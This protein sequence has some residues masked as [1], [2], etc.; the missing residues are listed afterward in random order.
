MFNTIFKKNAFYT[1]IVSDLNSEGAGVIKIDGFPFFVEGVIPGEEI[2]FKAIK[3]QKNYGYGKIQDIIQSSPH[4][5]APKD[6]LG[7]QI[8]TMTLQHLSYPYQLIF[9]QKV[10]QDAF[11]RIGHFQDLSIHPPLGMENPWHY[12]NKAQI[13]VRMINGLLE[14][15]FYRQHSH[16]LIPIED[17]HIQHPEID[18]AILIIR[19]LLRQYQISAY[20][21]TH[22]KGL[23]RHL[24]VKRGH[25]S[26]Q[27]MVIL[28]TNGHYGSQMLTVAQAIHEA[29]PQVVSIIQNIQT[30]QT[31]VILGPDNRVLWGQDY[32]EDTMLNHTLRISAHSFYQVNTPQAEVLY[33]TAINAAQLK[34]QET[35][36]DAYSGIGSIALSLAPHASHVYAMEIVPE[37]I[38]MA[39]QNAKINH[40]ENITFEL[41]SAPEWMTRWDQA[42]I[43]FDVALVDPPRKGLD[44]AFITTLVGQ[45]PDR[46]VY[47]SCNPATLARD[48]RLMVDAGYRITMVQPVDLFAQTKHVECVALLTK[49]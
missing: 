16:D 7:R 32:Y 43:H 9:K 21:E 42:G 3:V 22:H 33:Q 6:D 8:G 49:K 46:I 27:M 10:V 20:D 15:G 11:E 1:G 47:I 25:Y 29:L 45:Q 39:R 28:V 37:A 34:G 13:P 40:L 14:T 19:D 24:I 36:L 12:R 38:K 41:G 4:R 23:I 30:Q 18:K 31:N 17:F 5:I 48:A 35:V 2:R 26:G 44:T